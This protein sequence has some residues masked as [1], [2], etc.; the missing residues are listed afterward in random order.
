MT[1]Q[2]EHVQGQT[3]QFEKMSSNTGMGC[4]TLLLGFFLPPISY[5][6]LKIGHLWKEAAQAD[7]LK[8]ELLPTI[9]VVGPW[10]TMGVGLLLGVF[11]VYILYQFFSSLWAHR[12]KPN[13]SVTKK[14]PDQIEIQP[15]GI[16]VA[17]SS[18]RAL[19]LT[20]SRIFNAQPNRDAKRSRW[21]RLYFELRD[22]SLIHLTSERNDVSAQD[23][24]R[25]KPV[26]QKLAQ[27]MDKLPFHDISQPLAPSDFNAAPEI[28][29]LKDEEIH[30][31][32]LKDTTDHIIL[33]RPKEPFSLKFWIVMPLILV[34]F[35]GV[36]YK[37]FWETEMPGFIDK[38]AF[39]I[40]FFQFLLF[41][42]AFLAQLRHSELHYEFEGEELKIRVKRFVGK[43]LYH[44]S[45]HRFK[46][47]EVLG[48][49]L[50]VDGK[51]IML[52]LKH[53]SSNAW[54]IKGLEYLDAEECDF[55][56]G[57]VFFALMDRHETLKIEEVRRIQKRIN[58]WAGQLPPTDVGARHA[59]P[60]T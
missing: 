38:L 8:G 27:W 43:T 35:I 32:I 60:V 53:E 59:V 33:S 25:L 54:R 19:R 49:N 21:Y 10:V 44:T 4:A 5:A 2:F 7:K 9:D 28:R 52:A 6:L 13:P 20:M 57:P 46:K 50:I 34:L 17:R 39:F 31:Q 16:I 36:D 51:G 24:L 14:F 11:Y 26:I 42:F 40:I 30:K 56:D 22:G 3:F 15:L 18:I 29:S 41:A 55:F 37:M 12:R 47:E 45:R 1:D 58:Q 23:N 48:T